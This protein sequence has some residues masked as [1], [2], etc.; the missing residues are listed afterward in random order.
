MAKLP[1]N[2]STGGRRLDGS[3]AGGK[4]SKQRRAQGMADKKVAAL[5]ERL[6][7][8]KGTLSDAEYRAL[9]LEWKKAKREL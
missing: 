6:F 3:W 8:E 4:G 1:K 7:W 9:E 5:G 2:I